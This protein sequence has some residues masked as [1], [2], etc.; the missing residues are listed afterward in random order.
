M[1]MTVIDVWNLRINFCLRQDDGHIRG[2]VHA[3]T[4]WGRSK[5]ER[6][7]S[8]NIMQISLQDFEPLKTDTDKY[9]SGEIA[10]AHGVC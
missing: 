4:L 2:N 9:G 7:I 8:E 3:L 5:L 6:V 1:T 10:E